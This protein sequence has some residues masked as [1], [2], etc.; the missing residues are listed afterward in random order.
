MHYRLF[1][2]GPTPIPDDV[3]RAM[4]APILHHRTQEFERIVAQVRH[5][6][7]WIFQTKHEVLVLAGSGTLGMEA[8]VSNFLSAQDTA[9]YV[10]AG[11]FG[12][13]WG[14]ILK[15]YGCHG[16][17]IDVPWGQAVSPEAVDRALENHP[18][19]RAVYIQ[20]CETSTGVVHPVEQIARICHKR[21]NVLCVVDAITAL[22]V[23]P[24]AQDS[25]DL[26][27]VISGSQ[28]ALMLPPGLTFIGVSERAWKSNAQATLP[29]FY[30]DLKIE[31]QAI[32]K[33]QSAWTSAVSLMMGLDASLTRLQQEGLENIFKRHQQ[34]AQ[35]CRAATTAMQCRMYTET[36]ADGLTVVYP[37]K[38]LNAREIIQRLQLDYNLTIVG[39]QDASKDKILR[40][41]H[42]GYFDALDILTLIGALGCIFSQMGQPELGAKGI[43][44]AQNV[45][46]AAQQN[47]I[48][49]TSLHS[50]KLC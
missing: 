32:Q 8:G 6:L 28:K 11:K 9:L 30:A 27:V 34:L 22:G 14:E 35:M 44:A 21:P 20:A 18:E 41:A 7:Q 50:R 5:K 24:L 3:L 47:E 19:A 36:P 43:A 10:N 49:K 42:M 17:A 23:M 31:H 4:S 45:L 40:L 37:P 25:M 33:N 13:R 26:D 48:G 2:P 38:G 12:Q 16:I 15:A 29:R 46:I 1:S 39:G